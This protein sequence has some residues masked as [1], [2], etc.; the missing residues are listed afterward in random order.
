MECGQQTHLL[1]QALGAL[2]L[3][4]PLGGGQQRAYSVH[5]HTALD[6]ASTSLL[7]L[8]QAIIVSS[9]HHA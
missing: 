2:V 9:I 6:E 7:Q 8:V 4:V 5:V 3:D 1:Y